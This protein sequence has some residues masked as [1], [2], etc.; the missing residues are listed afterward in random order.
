MIEGDGKRR[1]AGG[2]HGKRGW[3]VVIHK[4]PLLSK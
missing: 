2:G 3:Y 1:S 4:D